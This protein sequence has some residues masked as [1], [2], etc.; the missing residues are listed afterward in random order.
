VSAP[1]IPGTAAAPA[2]TAGSSAQ[3]GDGARLAVGAFAYFESAIVPFADANVSI[4]THALNYGTAVFEGIRAYRQSDGGLAL[5]FGLEHYRR[6]LRNGR[7]LKASVS[8][9]A[10]DLVEITREM[11]R[12]NGEVTDLYIRP[13]LYKASASIRLQLS[14]MEDRIAIFSF[15]LGDYVPT[16]GLRVAF[17]AWQRVDDNALPARGKITGSYVNA[18]LAVEDAKAGGYAEA[19]LLTADG[20]VAEASSANLFVVTGRQ[21]A[22]PPLS[23]NVLPG[24]TRDAV[25]V[26]A[27]DAGYDVVER[28]ID[29]T[30]LYLAD[31][32]FLCGTGVQIAAI[33]SIDG[34]PIG[35]G[36]SFPV[37]TGLQRTYFAA[38][39]GN[40]PRYSAWLTRV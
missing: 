7:L 10:E 27:R 36:S 2:A 9:S 25:M 34:R 39:R 26:L 24:V 20:H 11:L 31:E 13:L 5:L 19:L 33:A 8:E 35:D 3:G 4:A 12:R 32:V 37:T 40:D 38:V 14:G 15:P 23:D 18:C 16:D 22:T 17:S 6:L 21:V 28:K 29:R 1:A 30:E